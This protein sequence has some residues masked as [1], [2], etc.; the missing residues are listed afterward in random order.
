MMDDI[1]KASPLDLSFMDAV[2]EVHSSLVT[3]LSLISLGVQDMQTDYTLGIAARVNTYHVPVLLPFIFICN[4][5]TSFPK[6]RP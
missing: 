5:M 2:N 6:G 4:V 1:K 3:L